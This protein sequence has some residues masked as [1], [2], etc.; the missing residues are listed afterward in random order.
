M[1]YLRNRYIQM[2]ETNPLGGG[3]VRKHFITKIIWAPN[4]HVVFI[5]GG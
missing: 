5:E 1:V 4:Y 3:G 2:G